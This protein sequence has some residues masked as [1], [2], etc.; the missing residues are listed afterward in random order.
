MASGA[1]TSNSLRIVRSGVGLEEIVKVDGITDVQRMW[2]LEGRIL[3]STSTSTS[4]ITL[5]PAEVPLCAQ[6]A[7]KPTL[8]A[9]VQGGLVTVQDDAV[10]LWADVS[11]GAKEREWRGDISA[12]SISGE[13]VA[14]VT[15]GRVVVLSTNLEQIG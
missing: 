3:L 15:P 14:I 10:T 9:A 1:S 2:S 8:A 7:S 13:H 6:L 12:A 11:S 5:D 4:M